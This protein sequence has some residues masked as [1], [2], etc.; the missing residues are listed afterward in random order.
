MDFLGCCEPNIGTSLSVVWRPIAWKELLITSHKI[1]SV[2]H[3]GG[4]HGEFAIQLE[5]PYAA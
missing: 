4:L 5:G 1:D 2:K 3:S